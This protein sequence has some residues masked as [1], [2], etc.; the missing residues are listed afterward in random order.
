M[1]KWLEFIRAF[2]RPYLIYTGWGVLLAVMVISVLRFADADDAKML[3]AFITGVVG[4]VVGFY[5][6]D[7]VKRDKE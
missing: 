4:T 2:V 7:R 1:D 6:R 5:V 3:L